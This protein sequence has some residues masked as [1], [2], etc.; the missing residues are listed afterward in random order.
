[1]A[2]PVLP[3]WCVKAPA[4]EA[5]LGSIPSGQIERKGTSDQPFTVTQKSYQRV[6][7]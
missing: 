5:L 7:A 2:I 3:F 6:M 1:M 4:F